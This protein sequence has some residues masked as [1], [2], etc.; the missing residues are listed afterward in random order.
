M[1]FCGPVNSNLIVDLKD[2]GTLGSRLRGSLSDEYLTVLISRGGHK[3]RNYGLNED[4]VY[5]VVLLLLSRLIT[6]RYNGK[7]QNYSN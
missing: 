7:D 3:I 2:E 4:E 6:T 1:V 5:V